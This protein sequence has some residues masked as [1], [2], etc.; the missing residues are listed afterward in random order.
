MDNQNQNPE[1]KAKS[2]LFSA[3][4]PSNPASTTTPPAQ[5]TTA[6]PPAPAPEPAKEKDPETPDAPDARELLMARARM[7]GIEF[8]NNIGTDTLRARINAKLD[9]DKVASETVAPET[10]ALTGE[11]PEAPKKSLRQ[12]IHD[13]QMRLVRV[14]VTCM[15]PKKKD[16]PG[17]IF[18]IANE[19]LG[20]VRKF[21][22]FGEATENGYHIPYCIYTML[23][24]R[25]FLNIRTGRDQRTGSPT[26]S[27]SYA[28]EFA[29]E[30]LPPLTEAE[31]ER[32]AQAQIAAGSVE[33]GLE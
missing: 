5:T 25:R 12:Q 17:E 14:R 2:G 15:D 9:G 6:P 3:P 19:Y 28:R 21:V 20:T 4:A 29:L 13:E 11:D 16:L 18:T 22:P 27:S 32:L 8:S 30:V 24:E 23:E 10:N 7:L 1:D 26:V 31:L 33:A